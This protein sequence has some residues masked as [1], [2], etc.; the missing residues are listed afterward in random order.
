MKLSHR[1]HKTTEKYPFKYIS[2]QNIDFLQPDVK[3]KI[4]MFKRSVIYLEYNIFEIEPVLKVFNTFLVLANVAILTVRVPDSLW[5]ASSNSVRIRNQAFIASAKC[6]TIIMYHTV[7]TRSTRRWITNIQVFNTF[8]VLANVAIITV[9][10]PDTLWL[11][12]SNSVRIRNQAFI[13]S[14][15]CVTITIDHT[16]CTRSTRRWITKIH[17]LVANSPSIA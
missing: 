2:N 14:A 13:A 9:R 12:S 4:H 11:A 10:V 1:C 16:F 5:L 8:L 7:C 6:G 17:N 15:N 3:S